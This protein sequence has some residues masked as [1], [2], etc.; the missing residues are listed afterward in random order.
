MLNSHETPSKAGHHDSTGYFL[1]PLSLSSQSIGNSRH[2]VI[3]HTDIGARVASRLAHR[4]GKQ[5]TTN[6]H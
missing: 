4:I 1:N 6:H 5:L 3:D 2:I